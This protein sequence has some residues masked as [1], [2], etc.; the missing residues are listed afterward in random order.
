MKILPNYKGHNFLCLSSSKFNAQD[1]LYVTLG[2]SVC[3]KFYKTCV[4]RIFLEIELYY[5]NEELY[6]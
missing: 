5:G 4:V 6:P 2:I 3:T 1:I